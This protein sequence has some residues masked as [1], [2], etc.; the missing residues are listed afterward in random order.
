M[1]ICNFTEPELEKFRKLCNFTDRER[2]YFELKA[3]DASNVAIALEM[4]VSE[5]TV[6]LVARKVR[7][8]IIKVL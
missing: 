5:S 1:K 7:K 2:T 8:K 6:S 3:K 4:H